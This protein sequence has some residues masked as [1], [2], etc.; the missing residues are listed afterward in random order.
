MSIAAV[1]GAPGFAQEPAP[2]GDGDKAVAEVTVLS[3]KDPFRTDYRGLQKARAA[4]T[5][6]RALAPQASLRFFIVN[7]SGSAYRGELK[8]IVSDG[9]A[10]HTIPMASDA[11]FELPAQIAGLGEA[12]EFMMNAKRKEIY[13]RPQ[14]RSPG[15]SDSRLRLGDLRMECEI[16]WRMEYAEA[17][18]MARAAL[19]FMDS[20]CNSAKFGMDFF[21]RGRLSAVRI[22]EHGNSKTLQLTHRAQAYYAPLHDKAWSNEALIELTPALAEGLPPEASLPGR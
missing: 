3:F 4:M 1:L 12:A 18:F 20:P 22:S 7:R 2:P 17:S 16:V 15:T 21:A 19:K 10:S 5:E 11:S 8:A 6:L 13:L 9:E 14:V